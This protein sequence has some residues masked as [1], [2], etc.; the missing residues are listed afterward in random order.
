MFCESLCQIEDTLYIITFNFI[1]VSHVIRL[2]HNRGKT[3]KYKKETAHLLQGCYEF[4]THFFSIW[5]FF[6]IHSRFTGQQ[7]KGG[8]Y[9]FNSSLPLPPVSQTRRYQPGNCCRELTSAH[10]QQPDSNQEPLV[11]ERKS[12]STKLHALSSLGIETNR[13]VLIMELKFLE[14]VT[15]INNY[16]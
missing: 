1:S 9:L 8:G 12:L 13:R 6:H 3:K 10:S 4:P 2:H 7:G 16:I 14:K 5:V 11:S 15:E